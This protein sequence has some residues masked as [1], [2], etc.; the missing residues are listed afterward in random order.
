MEKKFLELE[1]NYANGN[2]STFRNDLNKLSKHNLLRFL[3][4][5]NIQEI[6]IDIFTVEKYLN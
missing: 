6:G 5:C 2:L 4:W 3:I 1:N